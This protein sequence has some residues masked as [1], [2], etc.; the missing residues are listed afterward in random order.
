MK[1]EVYN[2]PDAKLIFYPNFIEAEEASRIFMDLKNG[3]PWQHDQI[4]VFGKTYDQPRLTALF[5]DNEKSYSYSNITMQPHP[6]EGELQTIKEK[7][8]KLAELKFT[9]CLLNLY[10]NG[11]D[12]NGWHADDEKELGEF[13]QIA[14]VSFG[15]TRKFKMRRKDN[16]KEKFDLELT[17]GSLLLMLGKTQAFWEHQIPKTKKAINKRINLTF[18]IIE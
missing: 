18:R 4:K 14:S 13:P 17:H 15:A 11:Q 9:T 7:V 3:I 16:H 10:R 2:L 1:K 6:F 12:S 8:E 5:A